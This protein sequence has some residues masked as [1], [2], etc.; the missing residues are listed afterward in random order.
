MRILQVCTKSEHFTVTSLC[1]N[2]YL[3]IG[4]LY[5]NQCC[6]CCYIII[7]IIIIIINDMLLSLLSL[8]LLLFLLLLLLLLS[9]LLLL[10]Y[11]HYYY[12][13]YYHYY[14]YYYHHYCYHHYYHYHYHY[15][16][17]HY[18]FHVSKNVV[19]FAKYPCTL[20]F[21]RR[22]FWHFLLMHKASK[23]STSLGYYGIYSVWR[24][25][26]LAYGRAYMGCSSVVTGKNINA[27]VIVV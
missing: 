25:Q 8:S 20:T 15:Y 6:Y 13:H 12:Y 1:Y 23:M 16:H 26:Q 9:L 22:I 7:I 2:G 5:I 19:V 27:S 3:C 11:H 10:Y 24:Y 17:Y 14:H 18:H 4:K 21:H